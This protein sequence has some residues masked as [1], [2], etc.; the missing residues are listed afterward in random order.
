M[1]KIVSINVCGINRRLKYPE[2][3]DF[4]S[5]YDL[6]ILTETKTDDIDPIELNDFIFCAKNRQTCSR[7]RS[8]GIVVG[9][10]K[11][12]AEYITQNVNMYSGLKRRVLCLI[13][14][15]MYYLELC[16]YRPRAR[17]TVHLMHLMK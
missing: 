16:I 14:I 13:V 6:L 5:K 9:Y 4:I 7:T 10:R 11:S 8:G 3:Q 17:H 2:F 1:I 12:L 15:V